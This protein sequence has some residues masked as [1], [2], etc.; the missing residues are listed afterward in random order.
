MTDPPCQVDATQNGTGALSLLKPP[1]NEK[2]DILLPDVP[3]AQ[4]RALVPA[5][6]NVGSVLDHGGLRFAVLTQQFARRQR[7]S[8]AACYCRGGI[9]R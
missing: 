1:V 4:G 5:K 6:R 9:E 8:S 3:G 2:A 7:E